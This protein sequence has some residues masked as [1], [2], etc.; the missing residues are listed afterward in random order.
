MGA[1][2]LVT[3]FRQF[4]I[5]VTISADCCVLIAERGGNG[6]TA[7]T[8]QRMSDAA[9]KPLPLSPCNPHDRPRSSANPVFA[10]SQKHQ[11]KSTNVEVTSFF[12]RRR[13]AKV[14]LGGP[15]T[16]SS[17]SSSTPIVRPVDVS[18]SSTSF[19]ASQLPNRRKRRRGGRKRRSSISST[20]PPICMPPCIAK[21]FSPRRF[22]HSSDMRSR[23]HSRHCLVRSPSLTVHSLASDMFAIGEP[24]ARALLDENRSLFSAL[25]SLIARFR[26][27]HFKSKLRCTVVGYDKVTEGRRSTDQWA[28]ESELCAFIRSTIDAV[29]PPELIGVENRRIFRS[30][31]LKRVI[32]MRR[33][34]TLSISAI[35]NSLRIRRCTWLRQIRDRD[36]QT[37]LLGH[38]VRWL[39][40]FVA[41]TIRSF[42][43]VT[44]SQMFRH[45]LLFYPKPVWRSIFRTA[46]R[47]LVESGR[48]RQISRQ[49]VRQLRSAGCLAGPFAFRF[50]PKS[51][52]TC[53]SIIASRQKPRSPNGGISRNGELYRLNQRLRP[54]LACLRAL[55]DLHAPVL[56]RSTVETN[57]QIVRVWNEFARR[58]R[59]LTVSE[60]YSVHRS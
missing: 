32:E 27:C 48:F 53:R 49:N 17:F 34:D 52:G 26:R 12:S 31:W 5:F 35:T 36:L 23:F 2:G 40:D 42:F 22:M 8:I 29:V 59:T 3:L 4:D 60:V 46:N 7:D 55:A 47:Q 16:S 54:F 13:C 58:Q 15:G 43:Y 6:S 25:Q 30:R 19:L 21:D 45:R 10:R 11:S 39:L 24:I 38:C 51:D 14:G 56:G 44:E 9:R 57:A 41:C 50:V 28:T 37:R 1:A 20:S 33:F 18:D